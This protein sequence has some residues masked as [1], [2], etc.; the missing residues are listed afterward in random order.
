MKVVP[1]V[2]NLNLLNKDLK[3]WKILMIFEIQRASGGENPKTEGYFA[4]KNLAQVVA[5]KTGVM[6]G[7][8][9]INEIYVLT[10][11]GKTGYI[12]SDHIDF[13]DEKEIED[14]ERNDALNLL[15]PEQRRLIGIT[16]G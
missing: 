2:M 16:G 15:T 11:D 12:I 1:K 13:S 6:K 5:Q 10:Q 9:T 4:N 3:G 8:G 14:K 7:K